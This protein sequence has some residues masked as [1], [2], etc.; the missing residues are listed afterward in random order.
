MKIDRRQVSRRAWS[1][2]D[3]VNTAVLVALVVLVVD[4][5]CACWQQ[6]KQHTIYT[7]AA[8]FRVSAL[9][10]I[11]AVV[12]S[13]LSVGASA[14]RAAVIALQS[15]PGATRTP[16]PRGSPDSWIRAPPG[17]PATRSTCKSSRA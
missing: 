3:V 11:S 13:F 10:L 15:Q 17:E 8:P 4:T 9:F 7:R 2:V 14:Q 5:E 6:H 16:G 12:G 1:I